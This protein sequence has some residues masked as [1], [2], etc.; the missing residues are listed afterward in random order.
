MST[1]APSRS[2]SFNSPE[3]RSEIARLR[4]V[5]NITNLGYLAIEY[6]C[7]G[8]VIGGA[9]VFGE[10]RA[11][12]G[13]PW[14]WNIPVFAVAILLIGGLMHRLAGLGHEASHYSLLRNKWA[15]DFVGDVFCLFPILAT[16][17]FY[18]LFHMAHHQY[19]NDPDLDPDLAN[20]GPGK[21]VESF[22]MSRRQ[23]VITRMLAPLFTPLSFVLYQWEY[24]YVNVL[25]KGNNVY[26]RRA[27]EGDAASPWLR[28]GT[29]LGLGYLAVVTI[30][31]HV[32]TRIGHAD[33]L[34]P[35]GLIAITLA[36]LVTYSVPD[37]WIFQSPFRQ[38]YSA[39]FAG[40]V[41][42]AYFTTLLVML[43]LLRD[44]TDGRSSIYVYILWFVPLGTTFPYFMLLRDIYQHTN[45]D[46]GR[47]TNTRVFFC[48]PLTRWAVFVYGQDMHVPHHLFPVVP[49]YRLGKLHQLLKQSHED[50]DRE[51]VEVHGTFANSRGKPTIVDVLTE[52]RTEG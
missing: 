2:P 45:A 32:L 25:G 19:T 44:A 29:L 24:I 27:P 1:T 23:F 3:L 5:D 30:G 4:E 42:L 20:L 47:L 9:V 12:G 14:A 28:I 31:Q 48:D 26:M 16:I 15:N 33:W 22:P 40:A 46:D 43:G 17:H 11:A 7:L 8:A 35:A 18:R 10:W 37:R 39:R 13:L 50:Y 36:A 6:L 41:R 49:H 21:M 51:V 38:P 52:P 34:I